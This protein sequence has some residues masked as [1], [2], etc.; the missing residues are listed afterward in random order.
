MS[1]VFRIF[2][3]QCRLRRHLKRLQSIGNMLRDLQMLGNS[4]RFGRSFR[5]LQ[6]NRQYIK[7]SSNVG[8]YIADSEVI[9]VK[10][11]RIRH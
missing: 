6:L 1:R 5:R 2:G 11:H 3:D 4:C 9:Y 7:G 8:K 10:K